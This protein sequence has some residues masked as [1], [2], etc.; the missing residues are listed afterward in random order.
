MPAKELIIAGGPNGAGKS[1]FIRK[2]LSERSCP[3]L[4]ADLIATELKIDDPFSLQLT[5]GQEFIKRSEAQLLANCDFI[6]ETTLSGRSWINYL[7]RAHELGFAITIYFTYLDTADTCVARVKERVRR[8]GHDVPEQD[9]RR[10]FSRSIANFWNI[11]RKI[12]DQWAIVYNAGGNPI[13][14]AFGYRSE[15]AVSDEPLFH[16][17]LALVQRNG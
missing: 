5:A 4:S 7:Q 11:Y 12:A 6:V 3:Y 15:F 2:F 8:G 1:T 17:F 13:E 10:R 14:V 9:I 16:R